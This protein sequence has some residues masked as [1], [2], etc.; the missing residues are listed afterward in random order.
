MSTNFEDEHF[1]SLE[2]HSLFDETSWEETS[3]E[4]SEDQRVPSDNIKSTFSEISKCH[5]QF[6]ERRDGILLSSGGDNNGN[7]TTLGFYQPLSKQFETRKSSVVDPSG[8]VGNTIKP[9]PL[10]GQ[11]LSQQLDKRIERSS[12]PSGDVQ[13]TT[14]RPVPWY[15]PRELQRPDSSGADGVSATESDDSHFET[16]GNLF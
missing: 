8:D 2:L 14:T 12:V 6:S 13:S 15:Y 11:A 10:S 1:K 7:G 4:C 16:L 3:T 5:Q 9:I